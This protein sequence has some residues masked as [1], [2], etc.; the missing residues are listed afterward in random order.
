MVQQTKNGKESIIQWI[1]CLIYV[2]FA[3]LFNSMNVHGFIPTNM[4][5]SLIIPLLKEK[6]GDIS[7]K[8]NYQPIAIT[9][10]SSN[11]YRVTCVK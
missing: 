10:T 9:C 7:D 3:A 4:M 5:E 11:N 1:L 2:L 6:K 8:D